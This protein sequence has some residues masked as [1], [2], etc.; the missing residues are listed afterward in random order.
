VYA[1]SCRPPPGWHLSCCDRCICTEGRPAYGSSYTTSCMTTVPSVLPTMGHP[2][3][4]GRCECGQQR[5]QC[6][7]QRA[8]ADRLACCLSAAGKRHQ[9]D[10]VVH[11]A[12]SPQPKRAKKGTALNGCGLPPLLDFSQLR[13]AASR[14]ACRDKPPLV[15][16][17]R[18]SRLQAPAAAASGACSCLTHAGPTVCRE[19]AASA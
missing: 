10:A 7:T 16:A 5:P 4:S 15:G 18:V 11:V 2:P 6:R 9:E 13:E 19:S 14:H 8:P 17:S 1:P 3:H 12:S